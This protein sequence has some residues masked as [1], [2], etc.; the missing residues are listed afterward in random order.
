MSRR[1]VLLTIHA[2][3]ALNAFGGA[4]YGL[5]GARSVP[6][7]WLEGSPFDSF[8]VPSIVLGVV[9]GGT[10]LVAAL[11]LATRRGW[12]R[13]ASLGAS[14]VLVGW[15][16]AQVAVI[17]PRSVLQPLMVAVATAC[18]LLAWRAPNRNPIT[19]TRTGASS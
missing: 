11:A 13:S 8:L 2:I 4:W 16:A 6:T 7:E 10:Q 14:M 18:A 12:A 3:V 15:I 19:T 5:S 1:G 17:G 9:V